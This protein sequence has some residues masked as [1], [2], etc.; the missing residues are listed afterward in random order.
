MTKTGPKRSKSPEKVQKQV[1]WTP[2][3][4][5]NPELKPTALSI[6][7]ALK[8]KKIKQYMNLMYNSKG[9]QTEEA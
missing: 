9:A 7:V 1:T 5:D 6:S 4:N 8:P 3:P 2:G